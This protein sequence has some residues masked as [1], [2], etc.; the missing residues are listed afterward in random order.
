M[1]KLKKKNSQKSQ[2][3]SYIYWLN[4][5]QLVYFN[6]CIWEKKTDLRKQNKITSDGRFSRKKKR[7]CWIRNP[8]TTPWP[9]ERKTDAC[10]SVLRQRCLMIGVC[11]KKLSQ[12]Q[13]CFN[14]TSNNHRADSCKSSC[15]HKCQWKYHTSICNCNSWQFMTTQNKGLERVIYPVVVVDVNRVKCNAPLDTGV[16][17]SLRFI[18]YLELSWNPTNLNLNLLR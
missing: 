2:F 14:C 4:L 6:V 12:K 3:T 9:R 10:L 5:H 13:L 17:S 7:E 18:C 8:S 1:R 16:G 15:C 11:R